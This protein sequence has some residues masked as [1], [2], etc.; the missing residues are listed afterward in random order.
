ME[1][2]VLLTPA[3][4]S[5]T[6]VALLPSDEVAVVA[7]WKVQVTPVDVKPDGANAHTRVLLT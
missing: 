1:G 6:A 5:P 4:A 3:L 7:V 2:A